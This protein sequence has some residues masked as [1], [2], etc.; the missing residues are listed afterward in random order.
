MRMGRLLEA[1]A[2]GIM[3]PRCD[4]A[5]EAA[6]VVRWSKFAPEGT[7]GFDGGNPDMPYCT[8]PIAEYVKAANRETFVV[9][10]IEDAKALDNARAIAAV[11]GVDALLFGPADFSI[12]GGVPGQWDHPMVKD[13]VRRIA[14]AA[15]AAGKQWGQPVG[16]AEQARQLLELGARFFCCGADIVHVMLALQRIQRDFAPLGFTFENRLTPGA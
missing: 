9:I 3:Y 16:S 6:E 10:Q 1:G 14:E 2:Q 4:D 13:A 15:R 7:R 8:M 5:A 11:S 12:L